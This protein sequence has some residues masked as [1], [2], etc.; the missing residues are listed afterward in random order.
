MKR[1]GWYRDPEPGGSRSTRPRASGGGLKSE[2]RTARASKSEHARRFLEVVDKFGFGLRLQ[3]GRGDA[4]QGLVRT[5]DVE[6]GRILAT[7]EGALKPTHEVRVVVTPLPVAVVEPLIAGLAQPA[8]A[9]AKLIAG[10]LP[11]ELLASLAAAGHSLLPES[12]GAWSLECD[13]VEPEQP[14]R[15]LAAACCVFA[16]ELERDP[17]LLLALHGVDVRAVTERLS[18]AG[19]RE[20]KAE[21]EAQAA[22]E[23]RHEPPPEP[24]HDLV[25]FWRGAA[26]PELPP[27][28]RAIPNQP[29]ALLRR[30]GPFP[31]WRGTS[32]IT[33]SLEPIYR[34]AAI[35]AA[36]IALG[37]LFEDG[38]E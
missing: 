7:V 28:P 30:L 24:P 21:S 34:S 14:C 32:S 13:C 36:S 5:L 8:L 31:F 16:A 38:E 17:L 37:P 25:K 2:V 22:A 10:E 9:A 33:A 35:T 3:R 19:Q 12:A 11:P 1:N 15:H 29:G 4:R 18:A 23:A 20:S 6:A 27:A 26:L